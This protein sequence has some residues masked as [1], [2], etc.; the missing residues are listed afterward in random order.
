[1]GD[2]AAMAYRFADC[3]LDPLRH[4]FER[5][6]MPKHLE[7]QVFDLIRVLAEAGG[8]LVTREDLI[9]TVW[10]GLNV[11]DATISA[12]ISAARAAVGDS[13]KAQAVIE[14][15]ARRG[16]RMSA[17]VNT[18]SP[19]PAEPARVRA[20]SPT[21][22]VLPFDYAAEGPGDMLAEGIVDEITDALAK[23]REFHVIARQSA[24]ALR[25]R[26]PDIPTAARLLGADYLVE[27]TVRRA[28]DRVRVS[29]HLARGADGHTIAAERF[30]DRLADL[31]DLQ[32][33]IAAQVAGRI[34]PSLRTAEVARAE[35]RPPAD[36]TA[37]DLT[38][39]ALPLICAHGRDENARAIDLLEQ[40]VARDATQARALGLLGWAHAQ[41]LS[42]MWTANPAADRARALSYAERA[43]TLAPDH[44]AVLTAVAG[45]IAIATGEAGRAAGYIA[46]ALAIDPNN[47]W[48]WMRRGWGCSFAGDV[49][50][51]LAAMDR[52]ESLSPL[53]PFRF[54]MMLGRASALYHWTDRKDEA[55]ALIRAALDLNP[56]AHWAWRMLAA[57]L[58]ATG[59]D[60]EARAAAAELLRHYP[61][62]TVAYMRQTLP[63]ATFATEDYFGRFIAAG[64]PE[65]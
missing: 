14:T 12:R 48:A 58:Q 35:T 51:A 38:L 17:P 10:G 34:A 9:A 50:G 11:S 54:N 22:A 37:Y 15:V 25:D 4:H 13:G 24:F 23:V 2:A 31:F 60:A 43:A 40:A 6:G 62:L 39:A 44:P 29:V 19:A 45:A 7:P 3:L 46:R 18:D 8:A 41:Q 64:V 28:G 33:R 52:A 32:D 47:A 30:D 57:S 21:L 42:Y 49:A 53:D 63:D 65:R 59:R 36:R 26:R 61:G 16:F 55:I 1:M 5:A 56:R 20:D 27:G